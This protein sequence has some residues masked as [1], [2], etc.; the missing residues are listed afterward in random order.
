MH[1]DQ[2]LDK[3][4]LFAALTVYAVK[5]SS[6]HVRTVLEEMLVGFSGNFDAGELVTH[7]SSGDRLLSSAVYAR[8]DNKK[9]QLISVF[10]YISI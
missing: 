3:N 6:V 5:A 8:W 4:P 7:E 9:K 2:L 1:A 10:I